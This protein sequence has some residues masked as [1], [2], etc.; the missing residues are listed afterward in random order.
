MAKPKKAKPI[1]VRKPRDPEAIARTRRLLGKTLLIGILFVSAGVGYHFIQQQVENRLAFPNRPPRVVLKN[2]PVWMSDFLADQIAEVARPR[3][4]HSAMDHQMLVDVT[5][6]LRA[7]PWIREVR[8][9][10]RAFHKRPGD[11]LEIDCEYRAP[12]A[13]VKSG[14]F[15]WLIDAE[16]VKLPEQYTQ[17]QIKKVVYG[18][19]GRVSIRV[20]EG[21]TRWPPESGQKWTGDD[22]QAGLDLVKLLHGQ[23]F[24]DDILSIDVTNFMG[25]KDT[26]E[27][28]LVL[29][30]S[31]GTHIRWGR[32]VNARDFFVE[33]STAQKLDYL[34]RVYNEFHRVDGNQ[35]WIDIRFDKITYPS[36]TTAQANGR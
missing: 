33:V 31:Y 29:G 19:D 35:P 25:R 6:L 36:D 2:R 16:G 8:Q 10:R 7:N 18:Q 15:Y 4:P 11:T 13:L 5:G 23:N 20:I 12:V 17:D 24:S 30:T 22:L 34:R 21:V 1:P 3:V 14:D 26:R 27:A 9:V 32:P 28:Q